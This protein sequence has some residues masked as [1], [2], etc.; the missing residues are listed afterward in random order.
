MHDFRVSFVSDF[1][2][3]QTQKL[4]IKRIESVL[5]SDY[6]VSVRFDSGSIRY[7]IQTSI[8]GDNLVEGFNGYI[9][10]SIKH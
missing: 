1:C 8:G 7:Q 6:N 4:N 2:K 10:D 3:G 5:N 9:L